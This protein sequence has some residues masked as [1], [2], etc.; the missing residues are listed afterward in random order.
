LVPRFRSQD[1]SGVFLERV[2]KERDWELQLLH[3]GRWES[4]YSWSDFDPQCSFGVL[5][6]QSKGSS[7]FGW[8]NVQ[9]QSR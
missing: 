4:Q 2:S 6:I 8:W 9:W 5:K 1:C 3:L 7:C